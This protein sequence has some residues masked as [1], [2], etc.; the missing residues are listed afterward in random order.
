MC[1]HNWEREVAILLICGT[2]II[3]TRNHNNN[4]INY[5]TSN[6]LNEN[7]KQYNLKIGDISE[8][9]TGSEEANKNIKKGVSFL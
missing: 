2:E 8:K 7:I 4:I 6:I 9:Y 3:S 5:R 1:V